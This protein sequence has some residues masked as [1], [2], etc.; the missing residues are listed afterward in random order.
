M[1]TVLRDVISPS[2]HKRAFGADCKLAGVR[3]RNTTQNAATRVIESNLS[4][5]PVGKEHKAAKVLRV[6]DQSQEIHA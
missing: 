5:S 2:C 1:E 4:L 6:L 3:L